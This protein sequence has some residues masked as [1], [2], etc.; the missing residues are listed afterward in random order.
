MNVAHRELQL[1]GRK[2]APLT[3]GDAEDLTND[4]LATLNE[5]RGVQKPLPLKRVAARHHA[6]ARLLAMGH[7]PGEAG[8]L[9]GYTASRVSILQSDPAFQDLQTHYANAV[10]EKFLDTADKLANLSSDFADELQDRM[11]TNPS[12]FT[13]DEVFKGLAL[14]ADRSGHGPSQKSEVSVKIGLGDRMQAAAKRLEAHRAAKIEVIEAEVI[15][16][17]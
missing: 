4:D 1:I 10:E 9:C 17:E 16:T 7:K 3:I 15:E 5:E 12:Q 2:A 14:T 13:T 11:D 6:L 8:I